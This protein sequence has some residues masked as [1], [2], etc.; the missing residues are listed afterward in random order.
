[1]SRRSSA[2]RALVG[3]VLLMAVALRPRGLPPRRT[4]PP[5]EKTV[6]YALRGQVLAV[7][8]E[9]NEIRIDHEAIPGFMRPWRLSFAVKDPALL[10][11]LARGDLVTGTLVRR[12]HRRVAVAAAEGRLGAGEGRTRGGG[13][14]GA[15]AHAARTRRDGARPGLHDQDGKPVVARRA[16]GQ[17]LGARLH[18]HALAGCPPYCP[19]IDR[20]SRRPSRAW[21]RAPTCAIASGSS[22]SR[23]TPTTTRPPC[24]PRTHARSRP[25]PRCGAS[26]PRQRDEVRRLRREVRRVGDARG[27]QCLDH[28]QPA[29]GRDLAGRQDHGDST[30]AASGR[31]RASSRSWPPPRDEAGPGGVHADRAPAAR[32]L[33][34]PAAVQHWLN[35]LPYNREVGGET[36]RSFRGVVRHHTAHCLEA[37]LAAAAILEQHGYPPLV[38]SFESVDKLDHVL[39]VYRQAVAGAPSRRSRDPGL[40]GR[41][42]VFRTAPRAGAQLRGALRRLHGPHP[43]L[44]RRRSRAGAGRVRLAPVGTP[45]VEGRADAHRLPAPGHPHVGCAHRAL[46]AVVLPVSGAKTPVRSPRGTRDASAGRRCRRSSPDGTATRRAS[47]GRRRGTR[48]D[49]CP[50]RAA[51]A[52]GPPVA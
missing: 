39:F 51:T 9:I 19:L 16:A 2:S 47:G 48:A 49:R 7:R 3:F 25:T 45:G 37:A 30:R 43:R 44:R 20:R 35:S 6:E 1:M 42:P 15:G 11:G 52:R 24:W 14:A 22:P 28:A 13:G 36:L 32:R 26:S 50:S 27:R 17:G 23:S 8:P 46:A 12:N 4:P 18:L 10:Q 40:H 5:E 29:H 34:S 38:L 33:R 31:P 41:Q 21:Q